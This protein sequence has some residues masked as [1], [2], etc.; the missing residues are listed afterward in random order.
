MCFRPCSAVAQSTGGT[1]ALGRM[2]LSEWPRDGQ[3]GVDGGIGSICRV[4]MLTF[5]G[6]VRF[7]LIII[8]HKWYCTCAVISAR[9]KM[10]YAEEW[11]RASI[12]S[13]VVRKN[14]WI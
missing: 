3:G 2:L 5:R 6:V 12:I 7:Y 8:I 14:Q 13:G 4:S 11:A 10:R 9:F 1:I